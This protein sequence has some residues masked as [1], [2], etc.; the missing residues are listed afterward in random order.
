M[1]QK[2]KQSRTFLMGMVTM[3]LLI[4]LSVSAFAAYNQ[5]LTV[6]YDNIKLNIN[7]MQI[8]P[9]DVTGRVVEPFTYQGTTYLPVRAV[10]EAVGYTVSWDQNTKTVFMTMAGGSAGGNQGG[11]TQL[12]TVN[13]VDSITPFAMEWDGDYVDSYP[14]TG[15]DSVVMGGTSYKNAVVLEET[16]RKANY[17]SYNLAGKYTSLG[18]V[19][20]IVDG[21]GKDR[22][23]VANIYGDGTLL[24]TI[25]IPSGSLPATFS[26]NVTGVSSLKLEVVAGDS[27]YQMQAGFAD[28]KLS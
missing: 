22:D 20:G 28:L 1:K 10:G 19:I 5:S 13:L 12:P 14:S 9:K 6:T 7:G 18:G 24:K 15:S 3:L 2:M 26:A 8:T 27:W 21:T 17:I 16:A 25:P 23:M 4:S 11:N